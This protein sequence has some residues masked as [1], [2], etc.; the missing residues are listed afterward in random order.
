MEYNDYK[1]E[2]FS[3]IQH[4]DTVLDW[5]DR[6]EEQLKAH[7]LRVEYAEEPCDGFEPFKIVKR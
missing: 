1:K 7:G 5:F 4:D 3:I 2:G 6:L